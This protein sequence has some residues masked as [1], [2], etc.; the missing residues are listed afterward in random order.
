INLVTACSTAKIVVLDDP[1]TP[2]EHINLGV[3]NEKNG[4]YN[5]ALKQYEI[6]SSDLNIA[7]FYMGNVCFRMKDYRCAEKN[8]K[9]AIKEMPDN[10]DAMN[11]LA[12][13]YYTMGKNLDV[14][15][16]LVE[17]AIE[18]N[19][20]KR[21]TYMDTLIKIQSLQGKNRTGADSEQ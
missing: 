1:L 5:E 14:A 9:R 4:N 10:A 20:A 6:A 15:R 21:D 3:I 11:N 13:L 19:P 18:I 2:E 17:K 16:K 7:F 8:Y 12:W